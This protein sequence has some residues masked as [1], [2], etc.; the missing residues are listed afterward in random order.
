MKILVIGDFHGKFPARLKKLA[1]QVDFVLTTGDFGGSEKLLKIIFK[2]LAEDW[3]KVVSKKKAKKYILE[4]Y[5]SGKRI[6]N[7][8]NKL[9]IDV[10]SIHGNWDF[11]GHH[12]KERWGSLNI[13]NYSKLMGK[14]KNLYFLKRGIFRDIFGLK[15]FAFGGQLIPYINTLERGLKVNQTKRRKWRKDEK[16]QRQKILKKGSKDI[17]IFLAHYCPY[18]YFDKVKYKGYNPMNGKHVGIKGYT[19]F[20]KKFQPRIFICGHMHEYQGIQ[21]IGKTLII[22]TGAAKDGKAAL[23]DISLNKKSKIEVKL[24][25]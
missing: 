19:E 22:A 21:K 4:D 5:N 25:K 9:P 3:T 17:D 14:T 16:I 15:L 23:I 11:E 12:Y 10:Y 13:V 20:I 1:G 18:G 7:E 8:L 2:N 6:I 24:I